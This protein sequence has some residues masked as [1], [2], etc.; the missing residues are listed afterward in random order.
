MFN[1]MNSVLRFCEKQG[2][3]AKFRMKKLFLRV[4]WMRLLLLLLTLSGCGTTR[5]TDSPRTATEMVLISDAVDKA[6]SQMDFQSLA[7]K[8]VYFDSQYLESKSDKGYVVSSIRQHLLAH[9]CFLMD[10]RKDAEYIV[11]ARCGC[12][13]TDSHHLLFGIPQMQLPA[14][15]P[16]Y[17]TSIPEVPFAKRTEQK[18]VAKLAVFAY[19]RKTGRPAWQSGTL[20]KNST[21]TDLWVLGTGPFRHGSIR[22]KT[23]FGAQA[24]DIT[25]WAGGTPEEEKLLTSVPVTQPA[26]WFQT[27]PPYDPPQAYILVGNKEAEEKKK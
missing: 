9:G 16:G 10:D 11:E 24:L 12:L 26:V 25:F 17:P 8:K 19:N 6:V 3:L 5:F 14:V 4:V 27:P 23:E 18:G 20:Q 2:S 1:G 7:G 21:S 22:K 15:V 13:G